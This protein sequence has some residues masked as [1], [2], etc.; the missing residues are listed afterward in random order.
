[1]KLKFMYLGLVGIVLTLSVILIY[2]SLKGEAQQSQEKVE[3]QN[4]ALQKVRENVTA[5][6]FY[7]NVQSK[8]SEWK[9]EN[10][11]LGQN[12]VYTLFK[13]NS[14]TIKVVIFEY[15]SIEEAKKGYWIPGVNQGVIENY[16]DFGDEGRI[17][18]GQGGKFDHLEFREGRFVVYVDCK[19][20]EKI[21]KQF[22]GYASEAIIQ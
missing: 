21:A 22:A 5:S 16:K 9:L 2:P 8:D 13:N 6:M 7:D 18:K 14:N 10:T 12:S 19:K 3:E 20:D 17:I 4:E 11:D 1:M 15:S